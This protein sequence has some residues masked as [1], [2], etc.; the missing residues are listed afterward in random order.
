MVIYAIMTRVVTLTAAL[1]C[2]MVRHHNRCL[3]HEPMAEAIE[4]NALKH[5]QDAYAA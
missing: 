3:R 1:G 4:G 5:Q 2:R